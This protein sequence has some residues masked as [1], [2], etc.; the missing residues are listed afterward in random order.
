MP[1]VILCKARHS[2]ARTHATHTR[3][4]SSASLA[5]VAPAPEGLNAEESEI[6]KKLDEK[7]QRFKEYKKETE[8]L[9]VNPSYQEL[10]TNSYVSAMNSIN[11]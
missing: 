3:L 6:F 8:S 1:A 4:P 11:N 5:N 10:F 7:T 9:K 2:R